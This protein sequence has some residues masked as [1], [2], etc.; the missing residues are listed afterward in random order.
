MGSFLLSLMAASLV[1]TMLFAILLIL[2]PITGRLFSKTWHYYMSFVPVFFLLGGVGIVNMLARFIETRFTIFMAG[3]NADTAPPIVNFNEPLPIIW[4]TTSDNLP[5]IGQP[6]PYIVGSELLSS[7][8]SMEYLREISII[9]ML[10]WAIGVIFYIAVNVKEYCSYRHRLL[11]S[12]R[13]YTSVQSPVKVII[14]KEASVPMLMGFLKPVIVLPDMEFKNDEMEM[15]LA[16]ELAHHKRKDVWLKLVVLMAN[17][18]HW[19]NP[20]VHFLNRHINTLCELSCDEKVVMEMSMQERRLY[21]ETILLMLQRRHAQRNL[22]CA[23]SLCNSKKNMKRRLSDMMNTKKIQKSIVALSL[24]AAL[25]IIGIGGAVAYGFSDNLPMDL[26]NNNLRE[27]T[28]SGVEIISI[29][30]IEIN[31]IQSSSVPVIFLDS[32]TGANTPVGI[33]TDLS[34]LR[35]F[36][37]YDNIGAFRN[38]LLVKRVEARVLR[39]SELPVDWQDID[40][41][42]IMIN[43][44][45]EETGG[46]RMSPWL[47]QIDVEGDPN[48]LFLHSIMSS[49]HADQLWEL[50]ELL[51]INPNVQGIN[52]LAITVLSFLTSDQFIQLLERYGEDLAVDFTVDFFSR[53]ADEILANLLGE[54]F[55]SFM[56]AEKD[57]YNIM[58]N[59]EWNF[60]GEEHL[61]EWNDMSVRAYYQRYQLSGSILNYFMAELS[62]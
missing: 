48:L 36:F 20:A 8:A 62:N 6:L 43:D 35:G 7:V 11:Q 54:Y 53:E 2:K 30:G 49:E 61:K 55:E 41:P 34:D 59:H 57:L 19:F 38:S 42:F 60:A 24:F 33:T 40:G 21:G 1:G 51:T 18:I 47:Y 3:M 29:S 15:I 26:N 10:V 39:L 17:A 46:M 50:W 32:Y 45:L 13:I 5:F 28:V 9:L 58:H 14:S 56:S 25:T 4:N 52:S 23:N 27:I 37:T 12:S 16:H 31:P 44:N 22:V